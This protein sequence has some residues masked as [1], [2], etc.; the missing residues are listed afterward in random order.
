MNK[1]IILKGLKALVEKY[2]QV[3]KSNQIKKY[4]EE[5]TKKD[6]I[7]P[8]FEILGWNVSDRNEVSAEEHIVSSGRVDYGFYINGRIKFYLEAKSLKEDLNREDFAKQA[9]RYSFNKG[10]TW[11]VLTDFE[12][13]KVFNAQAVSRYLGDKLYFEISYDKYIERLDQL[14]QLSKDAFE[15]DLIDFEAKKVGKMLQKVPVGE[16]LY[17][18][19]KECREIL[20]HDLSLWNEK[21][22]KEL[23]DEGVQKILDRLIFLRVA[24]DRKIESPTLIPLIRK[25][26][27][28]DRKTPLYKSMISTFRE[29]D[30][31]YNSNLFSKHPFEE[32]EDYSDAT[33]KVINILYGKEGYYEYDFK[34]MPAD[35]LGGVYENYLGYKLSQSKKG[36]SVGQNAKKRKEQGIYYTPTFIVDYIVRNAL[37][38]VLDKCKN[39][40]DLMKIK[41]LDP[42]CG[43]GSFLIKALDI[44]NEKYKEFGYEGNEFTKIQIILQNLYG[45]DLDPQA[46]EIARL[47][48]LINTLEQRGIMPS[49][50]KNIK[51]GNSLISG[52]DE[53]LEKYFGKNF[54]DK[55]PFNWKEEFPEVFKQGGFDVVIGNPPYG[56]DLSE[57]D[58][59]YFNVYSKI[60]DYQLDTYILFVEKALKELLKKD[61]LL[62]FIIPNTWLT[63]IKSKLF[64]EHISK[65]TKI[66]NIVNYSKKVFSSATV[67]SVTL[68]VEKSISNETNKINISLVDDGNNPKYRN[69]QVD[70]LEWMRGDVFNIFVSDTEKKM[71]RKI[72][73]N[74]KMLSD[75]CHVTV[76]LKPYQVGKGIPKQVRET[77]E[78]RIYDSDKKLD[79]DYRLYIRGSDINKYY[80]NNNKNQWIK[81]GKWLA[82]PRKKDIFNDKNKIVIR[83]TGDSLIATIDNNGFLCLNNLHTINLKDRNFDLRYILGLINSKLLN[84]Y[85]Q[86]LNPE[87]G[88]ALAEVKATNVKR[89]PF[90]EISKDKQNNI[91]NFVSE[92]LN[93]NQELSKVTKNSNGWNSIKADI[94][95]TDRKID[96]EVYELYNLTSEEIKIVEENN[97]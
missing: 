89:L 76:G 79:K 4:S 40:N 17:K 11:A 28:T 10:V 63:N 61:G 29:L 83:Q 15:K 32:W 39:V 46:V 33:K 67:D 66:L 25:W 52:T 24:E 43:S 21:V 13:I 94:A 55:K 26:E 51:N 9:I 84:Y 96:G 81:Y 91:I 56:A 49:L 22:D 60:S 90:K 58:K 95:K 50:D 2:E 54:R 72:E 19:L 37:K 86:Y 69:H 75:I 47:N 44:I 23:L 31:V 68:I 77:V 30:S 57:D 18:D 42:A 48:L 35:I 62:G 71:I 7:L 70:Q 8:L 88:E 97:E 74:S 80:L 59:K 1:D 20:L 27:S 64:R 82:E 6:F 41:V 45:V 5:E 36:L 85:F 3:K 34:A 38:P 53:E 14:L 78:K 12:S 65:N 92:M 16:L 73:N 87:K 93:L